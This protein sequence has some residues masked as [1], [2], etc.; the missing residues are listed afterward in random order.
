VDTG[1]TRQ[2]DISAALRRAAIVD[3]TG[4]PRFTAGHVLQL[5][6]TLLLGIALLLG[7][8]VASIAVGLVGAAAIGAA[9]LRAP[10]VPEPEVDEYFDERTGLPL[11]SALPIVVRDEHAMVSL[12]GRVGI[13]ILDV[14]GAAARFRRGDD[15]GANALMSMVIHRLEGHSWSY[16]LGGSFSPLFFLDSPSTIVILRRDLLG[17]QSNQWL[18]ERLL[19]EIS[20][21]MPWEGGF[22]RPEISIGGAT[23]PVADGPSL[24]SLAAL[25]RRDA[26]AGGPGTVTI[27]GL[28]RDRRAPS[29]PVEVVA[30][31]GTTPIGI[32]F[33]SSDPG[34]R[35]GI[36]EHLASLRTT[37]N[38]GV[39]ALAENGARPLIGAS[40]TALSHPAAAS[41]LIQR[42]V[43][44]GVDGRVGLV[45]PADFPTTPDHRAVENVEKLHRAGFL[46]IADRREAIDHLKTLPFAPIDVVMVGPDFDDLGTGSQAERALLDAAREC[47]AVLAHARTSV[48]PEV[49]TLPSS[50]LEGAERLNQGGRPDHLAKAGPTGGR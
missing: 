3:V 36:F 19:D 24:V 4:P 21:P 1:G 29:N 20:T 6:G 47:H 7:H 11:A 14:H 33:E 26:R 31:D 46:V 39:L 22:V 37:F 10:S 44:A 28:E 35:V 41:D 34:S 5:I 15:R 17:D 50:L 25:G 23:G 42:A 45:L 30:T 27:R 12:T 40:V 2:G 43:S 48:R 32:L 16:P 18:A 38:R 13:L 8:L 9:L 49:P